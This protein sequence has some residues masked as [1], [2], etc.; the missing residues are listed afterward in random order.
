MMQMLGFRGGSPAAASSSSSPTPEK[1]PA[2]M[3]SNPRGPNP[4][5]GASLAATSGPLGPAR[6]LRLVYCDD[7]GVFRMDPEAVATLQLVKGPIGVVAVCGRARQGKSYILNQLLGRS[8]GFQVAS[9]QRPCTKGL[10]MWSAPLRRTALDGTE[11]NLL[12]LDS[13]GIDAY[14]QTGTYSIQIFSLAVLLSSLFIYNQMGGIDEAALD[15]LSLVTEMTRHIRVRSTGTTKSE[16]GQ[17][18]P[19][20]VWLL[21]DFYLSLSEDSQKISPRD[22]LELALRPMHGGGKDVFSKNEIRESIRTLFP[23]RECFT[24]VRPL[25]DENGLRHLDQIPLERLRE[26]FRSGLDALTNFIFERTRPKQVGGTVMTGPILAALTQSFLDA[27]NHGAVPTISS[28]WKSVEEAECRKAYDFATETYMS[29]F[30]RTKPAD[31]DAVREAHEDAVQKSLDAFNS[32]AVGAGSARLNY[33][34]NLRNFFRKAFEDYKRT[35][36]LEA[37]MRCSSTIQGMESKLRQAC[38]VP[39]ARL[40]NAIKVLNDLVSEYKSS[41]HGP[42]RWKMLATFLSQCLEGPIFD[43]FKKQLHQTESERSTL[44]LKFRSNEDKL[45]LLQKQLEANENHRSEY[46]KRYEEAVTDKK[47][48]SEDLSSR[49][50]NL[51]GKCSTIEERCMSLSKDLDLARNESSDWR[52]KYDQCGFQLSAAEEKFNAKKSVLESKYAVAEGR[53]AAAREQVVSAQVEAL[54]WKRK[55][56]NASGEVKSALEKAGLLQEQVNKKSQ[57]REDAI[58]E[59]FGAQLVEKEEEIK[60]LSAKLEHA[61]NIVTTLGAQLEAAETKVALQEEETVGLKNEI[62][63]LLEKMDAMKVMAQSYE[64]ESKILE[65]ENKHLE[66]KLLSEI[67]FFDEA[68]ERCKCAERDANRA[69]ELAD[70]AR[71]EL[72]MIQKEKN[73]VQRLALERLAVIERVERQ[74]DIL[75]QDKAKL[76]GEVGMLHQSERDALSKVMLLEK[77]VEEREKEIEDFLNQSNEQRSNTVQVL[78]S[79]L[80]TERAT[81]AEANTRAEALSLQLQAT[82][83]KL[84]SLQQE[85]TSIRLVESGRDSKL[86]SV[87]HGKRFRGDSNFGMGSRQCTEVGEGEERCAKRSKSTTSPLKYV[88]SECGGSYRGEDYVSETQVQETESDDYTKFTMLKL[89]QELNKHGFGA[90]LLEMKNPTKKEILSLYQKHV[91]GM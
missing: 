43:L 22:Y 57:E 33:E 19:V 60:N 3:T 15:R 80:A 46:L 11:Y 69:V 68:E 55:Y 62:K 91:L 27:I 89:K 78:E 42:S 35:V 65:Q 28:S 21:R 87:S 39:D 8:S 26:E 49:I 6:P 56:D 72:L 52:N 85:M 36:F 29:S 16:L 58:R 50:V 38:H 1:S 23:E 13:E 32:I 77:R 71:A 86:R 74:V 24:L 88:S 4:N 83:G 47:K 84:D 67:K 70:A 10:W 31:E 45:E 79:L 40:E 66:E 37:D 53:L 90:E 51:Q 5:P 44:A 81:R 25:N 82:Q 2:S 75:E 63:E 76:L 14:D 20:F 73:E 18:S 48:F 34:K 30:D 17:F 12:L 7:K 64:K 59:E 54:E 9:T 41:S 61:S